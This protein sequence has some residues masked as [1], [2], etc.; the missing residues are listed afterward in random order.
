[1]K[2]EAVDLAA[3]E[4]ARMGCP[5]RWIRELVAEGGRPMTDVTWRRYW[6]Q[7]TILAQEGTSGATS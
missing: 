3:V 5:E 6:R 2:A 4:C 7:V 1:M